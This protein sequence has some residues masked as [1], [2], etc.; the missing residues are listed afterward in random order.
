MSEEENSSGVP[1]LG[2][3][4]EYDLWE[5]QFQFVGVDGQEGGDCNIIDV[6]P[7]VNDDD[8]GQDLFRDRNG[9]RPDK[10]PLNGVKNLKKKA[11]C[12]DLNER[13][14]VL[15]EQ[16]SVLTDNQNHSDERYT[17]AKQENATLQARVLMLE[18]QLREV[19]LRAQEKLQDEE[20]RHRELVARVDRE[21]NYK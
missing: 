12:A 2:H 19:E 1:S 5:G 18:E 4:L 7:V 16:M 20:R 3:G 15:Q 13:V 10:H 9:N 6:F 11:W 14:Q 8:E 21:N 17:R